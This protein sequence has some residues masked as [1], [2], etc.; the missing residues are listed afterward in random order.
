IRPSKVGGMKRFAWKKFAVVTALLVGMVWLFG[1]RAHTFLWG[2]NGKAD[3]EV[4]GY[5]TDTAPSPSKT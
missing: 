1:P 4:E 3:L 2:G 5:Q